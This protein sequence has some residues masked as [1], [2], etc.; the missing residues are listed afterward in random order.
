MFKIIVKKENM[1]CKLERN[2][3][4]RYFAPDL[5]LRLRDLSKLAN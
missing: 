1:D 3:I 4:F 2:D 5:D